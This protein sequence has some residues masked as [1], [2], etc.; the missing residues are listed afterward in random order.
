VRVASI[1]LLITLLTSAS[2][3]SAQSRPVPFP[4]I[5]VGR[6]W[7]NPDPSRSTIPGPVVKSGDYDHVLPGL[8]IGAG[9]G[10]VLGYLFYDALCEGACT[11]SPGPLLLRGALIGGALGALIGIIAEE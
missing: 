11:S 1:G 9:V 3:A 2:Q 5:D 10:I 8:L 7:L 4:T 6:Q